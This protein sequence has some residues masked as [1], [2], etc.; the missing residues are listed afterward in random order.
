MNQK[1]LKG[2]S[3][4]VHNVLQREN[5]VMPR[6]RNNQNQIENHQEEPQ[7]FRW[8]APVKGVV[9]ANFDVLV[10]ENGGSSLRVIF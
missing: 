5:D 4:D 8:K 3:I 1:F 2:E 7:I 10:K 9:K 6:K